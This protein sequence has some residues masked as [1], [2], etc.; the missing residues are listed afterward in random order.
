MRWI[1][2]GLV[3]AGLLFWW[4]TEPPSLNPAALPDHVADSAN[5]ELFFHAGS[6]A[7]CHG[8]DL[9]GG[10]NLHSDFGTFVV[11]N[12]S[13]DSDSGIGG[14]S[15]LAF[16]NAMMLGVSPGGRHYYP[17]F[18][19]TSY[20]R[21]KV[22][23]LL[24]LKAYLDTFQ[25][26]SNNPGPHELDF[27]WNVRRG[28]GLWKMRYLSQGPVVADTSGSS[29]IERGRYLVEG[30]GHCAECH[31][32]RDRFGGLELN[33]WLAGAAN[34]DGEG[35]VPNIT[36]H[37]DGLAAWSE[38]EIAYYLESGFTPD[39][40]TVGGSMV[41]VQENLARLTDAD[42]KAISAYLKSIP[43]RP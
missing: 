19:Y 6:C 40:D 7:S 3:V 2:A 16:V 38:S 15:D 28:I 32:S 5:G 14:W 43:A 39:F 21:M 26:V 33:Q 42:R 41:A 29:E 22:Q 25:P 20:T 24:D 11:P 13:P 18:P 36:P 4:V 37:Q 34:P 8:E 31:T 27:P 10:L 12:I 30:A 1:L 35:R 23:D 17:S 9:A